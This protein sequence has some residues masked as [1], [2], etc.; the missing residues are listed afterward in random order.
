[1]VSVSQLNL[2]VRR[3]VSRAARPGC[4]RFH[5]SPPGEDSAASGRG[6]NDFRERGLRAQILFF[7]RVWNAQ[8]KG[9]KTTTK[10]PAREEAGGVINPS[11]DPPPYLYPVS[12]FFFVFF[13]PTQQILY[14]G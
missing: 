2:A 4:E 7:L 12:T 10:L 1:M 8:H 3:R 6:C 14:I 13:F 9:K 11:A 5:S